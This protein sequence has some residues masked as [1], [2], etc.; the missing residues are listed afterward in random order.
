MEETS[1][2]VCVV[3]TRPVDEEEFK[4]D[5][6]WRPVEAR[7]VVVL[8]SEELVPWVPGGDSNRAAVSCTEVSRVSSDPPVSLSGPTGR[9]VKLE[10]SRREGGVE[11]EGESP[12]G[13]S[14]SCAVDLLALSSGESRELM[15]VSGAAGDVTALWQEFSGAVG[16][17]FPRAATLFPYSSRLFVEPVSS[18]GGAPIAKLPRGIGTPPFLSNLA[19][20][21]RRLPRGGVRDASRGG[22]E[23]DG[24]GEGDGDGE[25]LRCSRA[26]MRSF[27]LLDG[28]SA[29][30]LERG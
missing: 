9:S 27:K 8:G 28:G 30:D 26:A 14:V 23:G 20:L 16:R 7:F 10:E 4:I 12:I 22:D 1:S 17:P 11:G 21:S 2:G 15:E 25:P 5:G 13:L 29:A 6:G 18:G 19:I 24:E 3:V